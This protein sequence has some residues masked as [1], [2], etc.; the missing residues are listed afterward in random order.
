MSAKEKVK[1]TPK[2]LPL[3]QLERLSCATATR[4]ACIRCTLSQS[5]RSS[6]QAPLVPDDW[7]GK[8]LF[9]GDLLKD[10][11]GF[12]FDG[13][14]GVLFRDTLKECGVH[15][16][17]VAF[18]PALRCKPSKKP[19]MTQI[20]ACAPFV[21]RAIQ[22]LQPKY[23]IGLGETAARSLSNKGT[24]G[25]IARLRGRV[26]TTQADGF[27]FTYTIS[28][29]LK[30][31]G[32]NPHEL[33]RLREDIQRGARKA[34]RYPAPAIPQGGFLG[35]DTE[36]TKQEVLCGALSDTKA[37]ITARTQDLGRLARLL[38]QAVIV[39]HNLPVDLDALITAKTPGLTK[40]M[41]QWLQGRRQRDTLL[42]AKLAD[43][44]RG[45]GGYT[46][47]ALLLAKHNVKDYKA[48]TERI[49]PDPTQW[50]VPAMHERCRLDAWAT[51]KVYDSLKDEALGP[52]P[53]AHRI[54]MTLYRM[55]HAGVYINMQ[56]FLTM[57]QEVY[58]EEA[59][60][61]KRLLKYARK[62]GLT[63]F[64][65]TRDADVRALVYDKVGLEIESYTKG[66]LPS[67]SAKVLKEY[68]DEYPEIQALLTY[69]KAD[70]LKTTYVDGLEKKFERLRDGRYWLPVVINALAA[71]TGRRSSAGPNFQNW[72][73]RAR[74]IIVSRF[75]GGVIAD[76]D[77]SKLEPIIGGWVTGEHRLTEYFTKYPN[78]YIKIGSDFF[79]KTVEK[80]T[81][82]YTM[83]KSLILAILYNKKKWS[84]ADD[85]WGTGVKLDS[86][87][88]THID[89]AGDIL[90][91]FLSEL[92]P[93]VRDYQQ[94][95]EHFV[96]KHGY[97]D[98]AVGQRRR[99]PLPPQPE[100]S[101]KFAYRIWMK[102][103]SHVINQS[104]NYPIQSLA[105]YVTG[106]AAVDLE[107][108]LLRQFKYSYVDYHTMLMQ[109]QWPNMPLLCIEV[110]D[111]LVQDIPKG[112]EK[113]TKE[114][115]HAI[116]RRP[117]SM[118]ALLPDF[119][120]P[121][122]VDTN[123]GVSWGLKS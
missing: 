84:L 94:Q 27:S 4:P 33:A 82:E 69:S 117:P 105:S 62:H 45:K 23:I 6:Y 76:N 71:K 64:S 57:K 19:R 40:A 21:Y 87:Y 32:T 36:Y 28:S 51:L 116:M 86:N 11:T 7:T 22:V 35:F 115:T 111:D 67:A 16:N 79:R 34:E 85:L 97:V 68:K 44:N 96:I 114:L 49:G 75:K 113:K 1:R 15:K 83:M 20:R 14:P 39:G 53:I 80:N 52:V 100:R 77:Y 110:H 24:P 42:V 89:K 56:T 106:C 118:A 121:L 95:Q 46:L 59:E 47:E 48:E 37:A 120:V 65:A 93:G 38:S 122:S 108:A 30:Q 91:R 10:S 119:Q 43:E 9:V 101:D 25:T 73:V 5:C 26:H 3:I 70:K 103:K 50:P 78:G 74:R 13:M 41:E 88:K 98:N 99:L 107:D 17:D 18:M 66:G 112:M 104:I 54:S 63:D 90:D 60:A 61:K 12:L 8:F 58:G 92:F 29:G 72:P 55:R 31:I 81:K 102:F 123:A 109:K 2:A